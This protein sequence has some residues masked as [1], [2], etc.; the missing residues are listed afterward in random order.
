MLERQ[1]KTRAAEVEAEERK[2]CKI[3][4][5]TRLRKSTKE[6]YVLASS[7]LNFILHE[8]SADCSLRRVHEANIH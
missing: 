1:E 8:A 4:A 2:I 3:L 7:G 6:L 5:F